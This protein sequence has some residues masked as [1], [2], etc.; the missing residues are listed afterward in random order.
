M[1]GCP[2]DV[3]AKVFA[4]LTALKVGCQQHFVV[5]LAVKFI[6]LSRVASYI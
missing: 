3:I 4:A 2:V 1:L 6:K 5:C